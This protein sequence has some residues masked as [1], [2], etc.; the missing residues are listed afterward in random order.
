V[1]SWPIITGLIALFVS[2]GPTGLLADPDTY[3]HIAAGRWMFAHRAVPFRDPFSFS[4]AGAHWVVHEWLAELIMA[5]IQG[6]FGWAGLVVMTVLSFALAIL[7]LARVVFRHFEPLVGLIVVLGALALLGPHVLARAHVLALPIMV[8]WCAG[9]FAAR[10][11]GRSPSPWLLPLMILWVNLHGSFM[12]GLALAGFLGAE[13]VIAPAQGCDRPVEARR[14]GVFLALAVL[15]AFVNAN[16]IDGVLEP[17]RIGAMPTLRTTFLEW[18]SPD[19][20]TLSAL[21]VWILAVM[22]LGLATG[23][24][25]PL[26]RILL[27]LGLV[28]VALQHQRH[29]DLLAVTAPL[30]LAASL[31]PQINRLT[32]GDGGSWIARLFA[33]PPVRADIRAAAWSCG[34]ALVFAA[35]VLQRPLERR[36]SGVTPSA[37]LAAAR[38]AGLSGPV[39]NN[40]LFGG[41]LVFSGVKVFI[42]GRIEM[43]GD[44]FL[45]RYLSI[46]GGDEPGLTDAFDRYGISW[47]ML[48]PG[49]GAL[50]IVDRLPGWRR[51]YA[52]ADAVVN[53]RVAGPARY[54]SP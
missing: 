16:G 40:E 5:A 39:F 32:R 46:V 4:M 37:A 23:I 38:Q 10:D 13:A 36:E 9:V 17:F 28:H 41:Y 54:D 48:S 53:A 21:E 31:A 50:P 52:D 51:V 47:T 35:A 25:L 20:Q 7:L 12:F 18:R 44:D 27:L 42:D 43:Y 19:F 15:S 30:A 11:R 45:K 26:T 2:Y 8:A 49:D 29:A 6:C 22:F 24:K 3:L 14:W 33:V 1:P 34:L